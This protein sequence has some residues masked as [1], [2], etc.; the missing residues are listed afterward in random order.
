MAELLA[1]PRAMDALQAEL[2]AVVGAERMVEHSDIAQLPYLRAVVKETFRKHPPTPLVPRMSSD[3]CELGGY[4][5]PRGTRLIVNTWAIGNDPDVWNDPD[6]FT[7][8]RFLSDK[9][10]GLDVRGHHFELLPFGSGKRTCPGMDLGLL[11]VHL[12]LATLVHCLH[13]QLPDRGQRPLDMS[14]ELGLLCR[15]VH[16]LF[17]LPPTPRLR[18]LR[19][20]NPSA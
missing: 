18:D 7:P 8:E 19:L 6:A 10:P 5:V 17:V 15:R 9:L 20:Y 13:W 2:D 4:T 12:T 14:S 16:P 3:N 11:I 1:S